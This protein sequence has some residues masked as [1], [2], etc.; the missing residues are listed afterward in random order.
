[1]QDIRERQKRFDGVHIRV[2][3]TIRIQLGKVIIPGI[4]GQP[5]IVVPEPFHEYVD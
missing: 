3:P 1:M 4:D 5:F 2:K